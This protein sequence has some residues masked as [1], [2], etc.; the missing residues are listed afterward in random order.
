MPARDEAERIEPCL[1]A[2]LRQRNASAGDERGFGIVLVANNCRDATVPLARDMLAAAGIGHLVLALDLPPHLANAGFARGLALDVASLWAGRAGAPGLLLTTD[3][4]TR[5]GPDWV[6]GNVAGLSGICGAVAGRFAFDRR[7]ER[8]WPAHLLA[9]RRLEAAYEAALA[10]LAARLDPQPCDPWPNHW[11]ESG[12]SFALTLDAYRRIGGLPAVEAGED[13]ALADALARHDIAIR[14][15]PAIVVTTSARLDGRARGGCASALRQRCVERDAPG[16]ERLEALPAALQRMVLRAR[17]RHAFSTGFH[18]DA[19]ERQL[20][21]A[22]GTLSRLPQ[23]RF[24]EAWARALAA[25]PLLIARPLRPAQMKAHLAAARRLLAAL[26]R[27]SANGEKIEP[28][29]A[30]ALPQNRLEAHV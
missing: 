17:L 29:F 25:S 10:A 20:H 4:D 21:L 1:S 28:V 8:A 5:V 11:T 9:R 22:E 24:G 15:D 23:P 3:A 6:S 27:A 7:E 19:W 30:R 26:A 13:R 12:A 18:P 2:L 16:D 14:H